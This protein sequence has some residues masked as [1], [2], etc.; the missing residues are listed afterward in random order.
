MNVFEEIFWKETIKSTF[1]IFLILN[2]IK[3]IILIF[4][5]LIFIQDI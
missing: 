4:Y 5:D 1:I 2:F 3:I